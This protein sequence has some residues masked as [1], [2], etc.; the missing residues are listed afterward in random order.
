[1]TSRWTLNQSSVNSTW[2]QTD[3]WISCERVTHEF[4][5]SSAFIFVTH[6]FLVSYLWV[7]PTPVSVWNPNEFWTIVDWLPHEVGNHTEWVTLVPWIVVYLQL[8]C[9][10]VAGIWTVV[11]NNLLS[12]DIIVTTIWCVFPKPHIAASQFLSTTFY[13]EA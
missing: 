8:S 5:I 10:C 9:C 12:P 2:I 4:W 11:N 13:N 1:M 6:I 3:I 7:K